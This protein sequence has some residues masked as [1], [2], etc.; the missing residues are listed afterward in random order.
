[1]HVGPEVDPLQILISGPAKTQNDEELDIYD[2]FDGAVPAFGDF[3]LPG[4]LCRRA[5]MG[6]RFRDSFFH[7]GKRGR[8]A[9]K[10]MS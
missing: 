1:M 8:V 2:R 6:E 7:G 4:D 9:E 3:N 5:K 10:R